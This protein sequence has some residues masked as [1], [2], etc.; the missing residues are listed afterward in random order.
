[1]TFDAYRPR[2]PMARPR[3]ALAEI[4]DT[5]AWLGPGAAGALPRLR[6]IRE[7]GAALPPVTREALVRAIATIEAG[8]TEAEPGPAG[9]CTPGPIVS[10]P[11]TRGARPRAKPASP[12][13]S[14]CFEDHDGQANTWSDVFAG[15][16]TVVAF[17]YTRC[18]NPNK[19]SLTITKLGRLQRARDDAGLGGRIGTVAIT[20]DPAFDLAP[21]LRAYGE[22]RGVAFGEDDR[23]LRTTREFRAVSDYFDLG[24]SYGDATVSRHRIEAYLLDRGGRIAARFT[25]LQWDVDEVLDEARRLLDRPGEEGS[26]EAARGSAPS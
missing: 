11:Q 10:L 26:E 5:F 22:I 23:F 12:P 6:A 25:R 7:A 18:T 19:C 24:V 3:T 16:P 8:D 15:R 4:F 1:V 20:Y 21:R 17:F 14:A 9:C 2:W 13:T